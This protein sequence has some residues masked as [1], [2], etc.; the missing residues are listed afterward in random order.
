MHRSE[1]TP[2]APGSPCQRALRPPGFTLVEVM[3]AVFILGLFVTAIS[4]LLIQ[5]QRNEG[6]ARRR[7]RAASLAD[8]LL[9]EIETGLAHGAAPSLGKQESRD[10]DLIAT[11]E[12]A[13]FDA[14]KEIP[15]LAPSRDPEAGPERSAPSGGWLESPQAEA[16]PPIL[17]ISVRVTWE[18]APVDADTQHPY[19]IQR[20]TFALNP[21]ALQT[22]KSAEA[23]ADEDVGDE[24]GAQ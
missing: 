22:L 20:R 17:S 12:V 6:D 1:A 4:Q 24:E 3:A 23:G 15:A 21:S 11:T 7:A 14:A 8:H 18:G 13:A 5:A 9:A 2:L 10:E 16:A 19:G